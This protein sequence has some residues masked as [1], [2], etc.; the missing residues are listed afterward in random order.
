MEN[1]PALQII[2]RYRHEDVLIYADPPYILGTRN[3]EIYGNEM[4]DDDHSDLLKA[5]NDHPGSV[6][7]SGY[8]NELYMRIC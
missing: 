6:L 7:L 8:A 3:G 5:L 2:G 1:R 4:T